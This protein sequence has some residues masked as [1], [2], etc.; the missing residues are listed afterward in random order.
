M[1]S[2]SR[3]PPPRATGMRAGRAGGGY[4]VAV[5]VWIWPSSVEGDAAHPTPRRCPRLHTQASRGCGSEHAFITTT[6][7]LHG[8]SRRALK[9]NGR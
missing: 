2:R 7:G 6:R 3:Q 5:E 9:Y 4:V 1:L 8:L